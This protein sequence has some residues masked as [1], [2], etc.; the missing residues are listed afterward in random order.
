M[1]LNIEK[2]IIITIK[3]EFDSYIVNKDSFG[4]AKQIIELIKG[5]KIVGFKWSGLNHNGTINE[6]AL[7]EIICIKEDLLF[8]YGRA[9]D[10][11]RDYKEA[12]DVLKKYSC[13]IDYITTSGGAETAR[14]GLYNISWITW[15]LKNKI[16]AGSRININNIDEVL[17]IKNLKGIHISKG[18]K[19]NGCLIEEIDVDLI[20]KLKNKLNDY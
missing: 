6:K 9:I 11:T 8:F 20:N 16:I 12:V 1:I 15:I 10:S 13:S 5:T 14:D 18:S 3:S 4:K 17:T 19:K 2:P 7:K